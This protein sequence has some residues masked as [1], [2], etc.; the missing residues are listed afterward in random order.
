ML[1]QNH[2]DLWSAVCLFAMGLFLLTL[3]TRLPI[4]SA[5]GPEA[6]FF[7][8]LIALVMMVF[9]VLLAAKA[10][11]VLRKGRIPAV[12]QLFPDG[13]ARFRIL[14]YALLMLIYGLALPRFGFL[15]SSSLFLVL[16]LRGVERQN[17]KTM[18]PVVLLSIFLSY[19][20]FRHFLGVPLPRGIL[21]W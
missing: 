19:V 15:V 14:A 13:G 20:L 11:M 1:S 18:I 12:E 9:S 8:F 4:W 6:G 5:S 7:P 2:K 21:P 10:L 17:W 16:I 3:S